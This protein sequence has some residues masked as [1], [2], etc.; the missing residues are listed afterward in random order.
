MNRRIAYD[1]YRQQAGLWPGFATPRPRG[2]S[3]APA[4][5]D[6]PAV[7]LASPAIQA[8]IAAERQKALA[9]AQT[10]F[11]KEREALLGSKTQI[12]D[13]KK[14]LEEALGG[15]KPEEISASMK[16][17]AEI[18]AKEKAGEHGKSGEEW[19]K[20]V[21]QEAQKKNQIWQQEQAA[22]ID[23]T[24]GRVTE[25]ET[26]NKRLADAEHRA[27]AAYT[28]AKAAMPPDYHYVHEDTMDLL[29]DQ[30]APVMER[31]QEE[32]FPAV[33]RFKIGGTLLTGSGPDGYMSEREF[34]DMARQGKIPGM[35]RLQRFFVSAGQG[36]GATTPTATAGGG[37]GNWW[38][39]S[40]DDQTKYVNTHG[41]QAAKALMD[42]S[43]R[44]R[45]A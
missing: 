6:A 30:V 40:E 10:E 39:M 18:E 20:A 36:S 21:E 35:S 2:D 7:D 27:W 26:E 44:E 25:L 3:P 16:R 19:T 13:E 1:T 24:K 28:L 41:A 17:L 5:N 33:A 4:A 34:L 12:L 23:K 42:S 31:H 9:A 14:K 38:K 15:A 43:P 32:G 29:L 22:L 37:G 45:P 8:A 11:Q